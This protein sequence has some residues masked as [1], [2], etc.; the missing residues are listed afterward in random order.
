MKYHNVS[1]EVLEKTNWKH[2][3]IFKYDTPKRIPKA[4]N[5]L[6]MDQ[7]NQ[8]IRNQKN[9]KFKQ[10]RYTFL[11]NHN[12]HKSSYGLCFWT[13]DPLTVAVPEI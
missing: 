6:N 11:S 5:M 3:N 7:M 1:N 13:S 4:S 8:S 12:I 9:Q 10:A 2:Q